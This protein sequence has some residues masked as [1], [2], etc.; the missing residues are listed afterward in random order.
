MLSDAQLESQLLIVTM[1]SFIHTLSILKYQIIPQLSAQDKSSLCQTCKGL[2]T[3]TL[4]FLYHNVTITHDIKETKKPSGVSSFLRA[5]LNR[6]ALVQDIK[7]LHIRA[8]NYAH[9]RFRGYYDP[10]T[11]IPIKDEHLRRL[12]T[13]AIKK[14]GLPSPKEWE[15][16]VSKERHLDA[17]VAIIVVLCTELQ[18]LTIDVGYFLYDH[19]WLVEMF[20]HA[21]SVPQGSKAPALF[22]SLTHF[23]IAN[24]GDEEGRVQPPKDIYLLSFY[25]PKIKALSLSGLP[26]HRTNRRDR[27]NKYHA[28]PLPDAPKAT[29]LA[30]LEVVNSSSNADTM[31]MMLKQ[32]PNL[33]SLLYAC[34]LPSSEYRF[35]LVEFRTGLQH[36]HKTLSHLAFKLEFFADEAL[37]VTSMSN[38][39]TGN[40]APLGDF[41]KLHELEVPL[42]TLYGHTL[43]HDWPPLAALLPSG[44][45]RLIIRDD[46]LDYDSFHRW[47]GRAIT[48]ALLQFFNDTWKSVTP[49][50]EEV[51]LHVKAFSLPLE[52]VM[53]ELGRG[54][55]CDAWKDVEHMCEKQGLRWLVRQEDGGYRGSVM[56]SASD[57]SGDGTGWLPYD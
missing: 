38:V 22:Q 49:H 16:A 57:Y 53:E 41:P 26:S 11:Y 13:R 56:D 27:T 6:P 32:T 15:L 8:L 30:S 43:P 9:P 19:K 3:I 33:E 4:H 37:D 36:V 34:D 29:S 31:E 17:V 44:L 46:L 39:L 21:V 40:L 2:Y 55:R 47:N 7:S 52:D 5:I 12:V 20:K 45:R 24:P 51:I 50:L 28:W 14:L 35:E 54:P 10:L 1:A 42:T 25:L 48:G 23:T 18:S